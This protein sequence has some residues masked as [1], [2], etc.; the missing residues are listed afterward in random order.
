MINHRQAEEGQ[1]IEITNPLN[2]KG[3]YRRGDVFQVKMKVMNNYVLVH[4]IERF[5][6]SEEYKI[7]E[8][9]K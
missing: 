1:M 5:I 4:G 3:I 6:R 8:D 2:A 7:L 9:R